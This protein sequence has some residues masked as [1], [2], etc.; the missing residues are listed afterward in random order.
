[1]NYPYKL[2]VGLLPTVSSQNKIYQLVN[3]L[4]KT[5]PLAF[6]AQSD[7]S[8]SH[9]TLFQGKFEFE[10][11]V[12]K[13]IEQLEAPKNINQLMVKNLSI[14]A[15]KIIFLDFYNTAVSQQFHEQIFNILFP[16]CEGKSADPQA[17]TDISQ[18]EQTSF[19][20]IGYPFSLKAYKPHITLAHIKVDQI[21][22]PILLPIPDFKIVEFES[23]VVYKVEELGACREF[24]YKRLINNSAGT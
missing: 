1:M 5:I 15:E 22:K 10:Q 3:E 11:V 6:A 24:I 18:D 23:L 20:K 9:L 7:V 21:N 19:D 8:I 13:V 12:H 4:K 14:W 16:I 2:G 17:F